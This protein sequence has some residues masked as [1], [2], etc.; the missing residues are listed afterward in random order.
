MVK[1]KD[2]QL[3]IYICKQPNEGKFVICKQ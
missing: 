3:L 1:N 2:N